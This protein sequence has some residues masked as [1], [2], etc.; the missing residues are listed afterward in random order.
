MKPAAKCDYPDL[1]VGQP[2]EASLGYRTRRAFTAFNNALAKRLAPHGISTAQWRFLR[3]LWRAGGPAHAELSIRVGSREPTTVRAVD[4]LV[5]RELVMRVRSRTDRR[6]S[7][8]VLTPAGKA[9]AQ[10]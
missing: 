8:V 9:L 4:G 2:L 10:K 6:K 7:H 3:E 1:A 5:R